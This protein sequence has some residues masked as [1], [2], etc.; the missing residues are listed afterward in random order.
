MEKEII[1][2]NILNRKSVRNFVKGKTIPNEE[3]TLLLKAAMAAPSARNLQPWELIVVDN[4]EILDKLATRHPYAK[5]LTS[6]PLAIVVA[7]NTAKEGV[8]EFWIQDTSAVTENILLAAE[9]LN[10]GAVWIG[11]YPR[12]ER[13]EIVKKELKLP[14]KIIPLNI[15]AIGYPSGEDKPKDKWDENKIHYNKW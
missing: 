2:K 10:L 8:S 13:I 5:M 14:D 7:G 4:R 6:A 9:A 11:C 12:E 1:L 3:K 15:I